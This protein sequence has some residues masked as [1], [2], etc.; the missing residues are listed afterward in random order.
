MDP[1]CSTHGVALTPAIVVGSVGSV[2]EIA[3]VRLPGVLWSCSCVGDVPCRRAGRHQGKDGNAGSVSEIWIRSRRFDH[4]V[5]KRTI[6]TTKYLN[7]AFKKQKEPLL[8][9][10]TPRRVQTLWVSVQSVESASR[11]A[12]ALDTSAS[13]L[14]AVDSPAIDTAM[15]GAAASVFA[16]SSSGRTFLPA[17]TPMSLTFPTIAGQAEERE[18][19]EFFPIRARD[20]AVHLHISA[21]PPDSGHRGQPRP[22]GTSPAARTLP[23]SG[24]PLLRRHH[25]VAQAPSLP[26]ALGRSGGLR[27]GVAADP[28]GGLLPGLRPDPFDIGGRSHRPRTSWCRCWPGRSGA[29]RWPTPWTGGGCSS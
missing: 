2:G 25:P 29:G 5:R 9:E 18:S 22:A 14:H 13:L 17:R 20:T 11:T 15:G 21:G 16:C 27:N 1:K 6:P 28:G 8:Q 12:F 4:W 19:F 3:A 10:A 26:P 23:L 7:R 24:G